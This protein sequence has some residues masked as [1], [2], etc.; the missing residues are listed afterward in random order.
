MFAYVHAFG[1]LFF[2]GP[3][4]CSFTWGII[5]GSFRFGRPGVFSNVVGLGDVLVTLFPRM[6]VLETT[7]ARISQRGEEDSQ[8]KLFVF[9]GGNLLSFC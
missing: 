8:E 4:Q 5:Q 2:S 3:C 7:Y 6:I 1:L 9:F